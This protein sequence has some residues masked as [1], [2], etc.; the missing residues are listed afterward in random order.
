MGLKRAALKKSFN[1]SETFAQ[2]HTGFVLYDPQKQKTVYSK[3]GDQYFIPA[4]N[5]K[6]FTF[7]V[8]QKVLGDSIRGLKYLEQGDS[9]IFWGTGDPSFLHPD[10]K[11]TAA[12]NFLKY[13][14]KDLYYA[15]NWE[16]VVAL[17]P[18]WSWDW[19]NYYFATERSAL[20]VFGNAVRIRKEA[21]DTTFSVTPQYFNQYITEDTA[22]ATTSYRFNRQ[23]QR[24]YYTYAIKDRKI[25]VSSEI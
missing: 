10:L 25:N 18:G 5:T 6:L 22:L 21:A 8:A 23:L 19:Y 7:Y 3:N 12:Y 16:Q 2:G 17:G 4:S 24:N 15:N 1:S 20:P 13:N 9:L 11:S 14:L